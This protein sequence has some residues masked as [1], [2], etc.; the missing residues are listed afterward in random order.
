MITAMTT[1]VVSEKK[2]FK[3]SVNP[4]QELLNEVTSFPDEMTCGIFIED[5]TNIIFTML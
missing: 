5:S 3:I 1:S 4:N 2:T